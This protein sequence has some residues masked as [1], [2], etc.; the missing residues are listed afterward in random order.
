MQGKARKDKKR[1]CCNCSLYLYLQFAALYL[2]LQLHFCS[3]L[4]L[5]LYLYLQKQF[6]SSLYLYLY[7]PSYR[8]GKKSTLD[9]N[10]FHLCWFVAIKDLS[11]PLLHLLRILK[12][13]WRPR[14]AFLL[15]LLLFTSFLFTSGSVNTSDGVF[16][17]ATTN[18]IGPIGLEILVVAVM[19]MFL[20]SVADSEISKSAD[21]EQVWLWRR[22]P[23]RA[24]S[25]YT[26]STLLNASASW[27]TIC[28]THS[29]SVRQTWMQWSEQLFLLEFVFWLVKKWPV[30]WNRNGHIG[31]KSIDPT[32]NAG[33][34]VCLFTWSAICE[35]PPS[36]DINLPHSLEL[37]A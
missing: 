20:R 29:Q 6:C 12:K 7:W 9:M 24:P 32:Q 34:C 21:P 2:Y 37:P 23:L 4:Y 19:N 8:Q 10:P 17:F 1:R 27:Q 3:S 22:V 31:R 35:L 16:T 33:P 18:D 36:S 25:H 15:L 14:S 11:L 30:G 13:D 5:Y 28:L 26:T